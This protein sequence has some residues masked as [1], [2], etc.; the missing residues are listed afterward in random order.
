MCIIRLVQLLVIFFGLEI[1]QQCHMTNTNTQHR[2]AV[3]HDIS[4]YIFLSFKMYEN[5]DLLCNAQ[6]VSNGLTPFDVS[7]EF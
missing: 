2:T 4:T 5:E 6:L 1:A 7:H 3:V